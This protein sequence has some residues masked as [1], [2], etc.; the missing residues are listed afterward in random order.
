MA[1]QELIDVVAAE[2][3][4]AAQIVTR[5]HAL[6]DHSVDGHLVKLQEFRQLPD[7]VELPGAGTS[8]LSVLLLP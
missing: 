8:V 5:Q 1:F 4:H 2:T 6:G 7:R 3:F